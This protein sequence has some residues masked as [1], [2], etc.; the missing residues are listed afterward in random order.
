M[1]VLESATIIK[2]TKLSI[3]GEIAFILVCRRDIETDQGYNIRH[4]FDVELEI[5][6]EVRAS[7]EFI[8]EAEVRVENKNGGNNGMDD[9]DKNSEKYAN[10]GEYRVFY[11]L[12]SMNFI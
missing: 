7:E 3:S 8:N 12:S 10:Q 5:D 2:N 6:R 4:E 9:K 11:K 1:I